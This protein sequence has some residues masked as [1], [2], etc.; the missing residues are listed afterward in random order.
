M[1]SIE[2]LEAQV[3]ALQERL[4]AVEDVESIRRLKARYAELVDRRYSRGQAREGEDLRRCAEEI[5]ALFT[6]DAVWDGGKA[7]GVCTGRAAI[8]ERMAA[9]TLSFSWHFF[10]KP[11]IEVDGDRARARWDI[12]SPCTTQD[13]RPHWMVGVEDDEYR[14]LD[15]TWLHS[16][17]QLGVVFLAP[18][19]TGWSRIGI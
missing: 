17:M 19:E 7:L 13:G 2:A 4:T 11:Q 14:K 10:L 8:A 16:R 18:H 3:R 5:A 6:E 1:S 12:L 15:G 9:P